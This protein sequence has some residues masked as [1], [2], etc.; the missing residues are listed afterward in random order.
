MCSGCGLCECG[1]GLG[2]RAEY[3][4]RK[5][6]GELQVALTEKRRKWFLRQE[7][8]AISKRRFGMLKVMNIVAGELPRFVPPD[9]CAA[10][11]T[12]MRSPQDTPKI[13]FFDFF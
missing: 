6:S 8:I 12:N 1:Y 5:V 9:S 3:F 4:T 7:Y 2:R 10:H 11:R 13:G